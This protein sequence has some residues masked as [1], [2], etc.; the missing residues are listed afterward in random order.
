MP[1]Q[2]RSWIKQT[3]LLKSDNGFSL[4]SPPSTYNGLPL[5]VLT[6]SGSGDFS[7][8]PLLRS[9][10]Q[11]GQTVFYY[12]YYNRLFGDAG[13]NNL[14]GGLFD[15]LIDGGGGNDSL[16]G[17]AGA[18][19]LY[20]GDG[21]DF[22]NGTSGADQLFGGNGDDTLAADED[23][24]LIDGGEGFD[25]LSLTVVSTIGGTVDLASGRF[26]SIE[27]R[28]VRGNSGSDT[29]LGSALND[30]LD[31]QGGN[32]VLDGRDGDD[33]VSGGDGSD[34]LSGG[35]GDDSVSGGDGSD[36]L[37]GGVGND[38]L[39]G[40]LGADA[41]SGGDGDDVLNFDLEDTLVDG[42]PGRDLVLFTATGATGVS[43]DLR[44][45][46]FT[47]IERGSLTGAD[48]GDSF[49]GAGGND[50]LRGEGGN[51]ILEGNSGN[52]FLYGGAGQDTIRGGMDNDLLRGD[53]GNDL[54]DGQADS[55][56]MF[57]GDGDDTLIGGDAS[58]QLHGDLG[59]DSLFGGEGNDFLFAID[60]TGGAEDAANILDGGAGND[61]LYGSGNDELRGGSGSDRFYVRVND[62]IT[63]VEQAD[64]NIT[65][66][67]IGADYVLQSRNWSTYTLAAFDRPAAAGEPPIAL[68]AFTFN[69]PANLRLN[70]RN[71]GA[72]F[73]F[74][75]SD[76]QSLSAVQQGVEG[77][78]GVGE[79]DA[80]IQGLQNAGRTSLDQLLQSVN[81]T[82]LQADASGTPFGSFMDGLD[83]AM[84]RVQILGVVNSIIDDAQSG[85]FANNPA[86]KYQRVAEFLGAIVG[87]TPVGRAVPNEVLTIGVSSLLLSTALAVDYGTRATQGVLTFLD[88]LRVKL[89]VANSPST[90]LTPTDAADVGSV[91]VGAGAPSVS[92]G[93][94]DDALLI[95]ITPPPGGKAVPTN[96]NTEAPI[97][98]GGAGSDSI[99]FLRWTSGE[100]FSVAA[101]VVGLQNSVSFRAQ[102]VE[103]LYL[104]NFA[105]QLV[106]DATFAEVFAGAGN[107]QVTASGSVT[108]YGDAGDDHLV[109][110]DGSQTLLG[111]QG[112][113][114]LEGKAGADI[115]V[116]GSGVNVFEGGAGV[117][118]FDGSAG[119][120][121][122]RYRGD[123]SAVS[124]D[125]AAG[126]ATDGSGAQDIL[127]AVENAEGSEFGDTLRGDANRNVLDGAGGGD[128]LV[129]AG[130]D[131][132][133]R[134]GAGTDTA[135]Y[136][137]VS[138]AAT[139]TR[140]VSGSWSI[141]AGADGIDTLTTVELLQFTNRTLALRP[142]EGSID[143]N[144]TTDIVL[145]NT[146]GTIA[147]WTQT[148]AA[149]TSA[150]IVAASDPNFAAL[151][152]GDFNGDGRFD[153]LFRNAGGIL[154]QWQ[155][156][157]AA[158][159]AVGAYVTDPNWSV[160]GIGDFNGDFRDDIL[161]RNSSG[162]L[163]Q[164]QMDGLA[165]SAVGVFAA[166]DP[167]WAVS[168]V[169]DFNGDGRDD[170]LWRNSSG[171]LA[172]W[173]M[174]GFAVTSAGVIATSD[175]TW[176]IVG[177]GDFNGDL[178]ED[179]L[180]RSST[181]VLAQWT[182]DGATVTGVGTFAV[183][184]TAWSVSDIGDYN[185]DG[186]D[187]I[188]WQGPD[189][190]FALWALNGFSVTSAGVI[191]NPGAGWTDIG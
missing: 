43:I 6:W 81:T 150:Q 168:Q 7:S 182:M 175:P 1:V 162:L 45:G 40:G 139:F 58:D 142:A 116:G 90:M 8:G 14:S 167:T 119:V 72:D 161:W 31:G 10:T 106:T 125:L 135:T 61:G 52:D 113:D 84:S 99:G 13:V 50:L 117:D 181:G 115:L 56:L 25:T 155:M 114:M 68:G 188:L 3:D 154:A 37:S 29:L 120:D 171:L 156:S 145:R 152:Q 44:I 163:A 73:F 79:W 53:A 149:T 35:E 169:A 93:I 166:S 107:D 191:G 172:L 164:W 136:A 185:G 101:G 21:A 78:L 70:P 4:S 39:N 16:V 36:T 174:D 186:R 151:G 62:H 183:S 57:G 22:L 27:S 127:L 49:Y 123:G 48:G 122:A 69:G 165:A 18:D 80:L 137:A 111:G 187:D 134:G 96:Q 108:V 100:V 138:S 23:D 88:D 77:A 24:S 60:S 9:T 144:G 54:L 42:G 33:S 158:V 147:L 59:A 26:Q 17:G 55:D 71:E 38:N 184:D 30:T 160:A 170:I 157:G 143:G 141:D 64:G 67:G 75:L 180:W 98:D 34:T 129:G 85:R 32:D 97:L 63:D 5:F 28:L 112:D 74:G 159:S 190:T 65:F 153:L 91:G 95:T 121:T 133:I 102:N 146:N 66:V 173:Q 19:E 86:L 128:L 103:R 179:I 51:D 92:T 2:L 89:V 110:G 83:R 131:D 94:G 12:D 124:V 126:S 109:G 87:I 148:G 105:D 176:T 140:L 47:S 76:N 82:R 178:R 132:D 11:N 104:T 118:S 15:D 46:P 130:G 189:G 20:G 41:L 177:T